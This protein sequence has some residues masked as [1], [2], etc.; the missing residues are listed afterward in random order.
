MGGEDGRGHFG[1]APRGVRLMSD[2][3]GV[4]C[5]QGGHEDVRLMN[6][7]VGMELGGVCLGG[8]RRR[9]LDE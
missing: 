1:G 5:V 2:R 7:M 6:G 3:V 9:T 4:G 8:A